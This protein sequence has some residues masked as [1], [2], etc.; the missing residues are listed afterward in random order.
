MSDY[1][2][3]VALL[4]QT[5]DYAG[6]F[7]PAS[8]DLD[9]SLKKAN[10]FR[11]TLKNP[12]LMNRIV[13][14]L[15]EVKKLNPAKLFNLGSDGSPW[16]VTVL[17]KPTTAKTPED[18]VKSIDWDFREMRRIDER[19]L[20]S[21]CRID[22]VSYEVRLPQPVF[23]SGQG[24]F[25]GEYIFPALEQIE[26]IWLGRMD[27]YFEISLEGAWEDTV[28]G[29]CRVLAEWINENSDSWIIPGL[30]IRTGGQTVPRPE[31]LALVINECAAHGLK[32]KATQGLHQPIS[33]SGAFGFVNLLA[34]IN[35]AFSLGQ[36]QFSLAHIQDC[37]ISQSPKDF[38]FSQNEFSWKKHCLTNEEIE[39]ARKTHAAAFGSC[40]LDEPDEYFSKEFP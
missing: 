37:L 4:S 33:H 21:S 35:F 34:A 11:K 3:K 27:V 2:S 30:K 38:V 32:L 7:P 18:F 5:I 10:S 36:D 20:H 25:S 31:Q 19:Y 1:S 22:Q 39:S 8:L 24:I 16:L 12:W 28:V 13:L 26:S 15:E 9:S 40:S 23:S 17:G 29:V 6:M 14:D